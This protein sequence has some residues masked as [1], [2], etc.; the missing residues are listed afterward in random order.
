MIKPGMSCVNSVCLPDIDAFHE[1]ALKATK[2][3]TEVL[4]QK[5]D[6]PNIE[7]R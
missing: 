4:F 5:M 3:L 2:K 6:T 1:T 7:K